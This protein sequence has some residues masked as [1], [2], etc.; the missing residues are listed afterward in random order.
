MWFFPLSP[1]CT[2]PS[3]GLPRPHSSLA[4]EGTLQAGTCCR[5]SWYQQLAN[6]WRKH[7]DLHPVAVPAWFPS[8]GSGWARG[9]VGP[10]GCG[11]VKAQKS[12]RR[13]HAGPVVGL[14]WGLGLLF[15]TSPQETGWVCPLGKGSEG[16]YK[17]CFH[18]FLTNHDLF[19]T[20]DQAYGGCMLSYLVR[21]F[22]VSLLFCVR[23]SWASLLKL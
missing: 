21:W 11:C 4:H 12:T 22:F 6:T 9:Q 1:L 17:Q 19:V 10:C 8:A 15:P 5:L 7:P 18:Q 14:A 16:K 20:N 3:A 23:T 2:Y 13:L